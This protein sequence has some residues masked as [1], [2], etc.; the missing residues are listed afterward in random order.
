MT[1]KR[2]T[3]DGRELHNNE[4]EFIQNGK[5]AYKFRKMIN[6]KIYETSSVSLD[7][8][9]EKTAD[10]LK[11]ISRLEKKTR[12]ATAKDNTVR[13][14]AD[15]ASDENTDSGM[16]VFSSEIFGDVRIILRDNEP[17]FVAADVCRALEIS[18]NRDALYRLDDDEKM[19]VASTDSHSGQ[20]GGAQSYTVVNESGL[21]SLVL[22][23]RKPEAKEFKRWITHEVIPSIRKNGGY[24]QN[25][26]QFVDALIPDGSKELKQMM[27]ILCDQLIES[28]KEIAKLRPKSEFAD[29]ML[30]TPFLFRT[31]DIAK[32]FGY[33]D[34]KGVRLFNKLLEKL[35]IQYKTDIWHLTDAYADKGYAEIVRFY[36]NGGGMFMMW[37]V[38]G[39]KLI[40]E[41][42][43]ENY[44]LVPIIDREDVA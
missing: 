6:G 29:N 10:L 41:K 43:K 3:S 39:Y 11:E 1:T 33:H 4:M 44:G 25:S 21:Y 27:E 32:M 34:K 18:N 35:G 16:K 26:K 19:T 8:M 30:D 36:K 28:Q 9:R 20:R 13:A 12:K 2:Y 37:S 14:I 17:W 7:K 42:L 24:I 38:K 40:C 5:T 22:G 15:V 23:S 31:S